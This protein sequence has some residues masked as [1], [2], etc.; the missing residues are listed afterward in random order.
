MIRL[1]LVPRATATGP[2]ADARINFLE[3]E[4]E[5]LKQSMEKMRTEYEIKL[6]ETHDSLTEMFEERL[7][8]FRNL[9]QTEL[10]NQR[11]AAQAEIDAL[12]VQQVIL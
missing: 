12:R 5:G 3:S 10:A 4:N 7:A 6:Q 11:E 8:E 9:A 1:I 2:T